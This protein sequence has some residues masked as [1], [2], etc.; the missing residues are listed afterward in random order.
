MEENFI[1]GLMEDMVMIKRVFLI[2]LDSFGIG[3]APDAAAFGDEGS[4]TLGSVARQRGFAAPNLQRLGFFNIK[5]TAQGG[6][7][8]TAIKEPCGAY[9]AMCEASAGKD[10]TIGHW[11]M[12]GIYSPTPLP[13]YPNGFP[14]ELLDAFSAATGRGVICNRPYSGTDVIRD[15]GKEHMETGALIVYT[16]A[17][18]VFQIAAHE[19]IV[20]TEQLYE[21]CLMARR[22]L[23]GEHCV[24]RVIAR[25][26]TGEYPFTRTSRRRDFSAEPPNKTILDLLSENGLE[27]RCIGKIGD[28]FAGR[29][30]T[31]D[32]HTSS[33]EDGMDR[34][35]A[36]AKEDFRG[37]C[38]VNLVEFDMT[39]GHRRDAKGYA[40]AVMAF[41]KRLG[42]LLPLLREDD[43]LMITADHGCDPCYSGTD[44]TRER[45]PLVICGN[46]ISSTDL[47]KRSTF[48][49][50]AATIADAFGL[51]YTLYGTSMLGEIIK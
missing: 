22:L 42:E 38:F 28:I 15:F 51:E 27:T 49:D 10:T 12:A 2:V 9:A 26:F 45:T 29:G 7:F 46:M 33:N 48:A 13:T 30:V 40:D 16:S 3:K 47:G 8:A 43:M 36:A 17:D 25:P 31:S 39:Y 19:S 34:T 6:E 37:L 41:D 11:E 24:G 4:D 35:I 44:H 32:V 21:Y 5:D 14:K 23:S 18:S 20:P 1:L 50:I